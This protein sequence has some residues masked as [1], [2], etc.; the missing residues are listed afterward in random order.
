MAPQQFDPELAR[1][2]HLL[3]LAGDVPA[4]ELEVLAASRFTAAGWE[5]PTE[6]GGRRARTK[7]GPVGVLRL[8]RHSAL[9]GP[10]PLDRTGAGALGLPGAAGQVWVVHAP[11]E[12][13]EAPWPGAADRDGLGRGFP[14]G[15]P[16]REE[17][18]V[19]SWLVA[20]ARRLGGA[21]RV[22]GP[23]GSP[24]PV[25]VPDPAAAVDLTVW[26]DIWLGPDAALSVVRQ[27]VPRARLDGGVPWQGPPPGTGVRPARGAEDLDAQVRAALHQ[28]AERRDMEA[29]AHPEPRTSYGVLADLD[30]DGG[31]AVEIGGETELPQ[32]LAGVPWARAGAVAY[33]VT[34]APD[35]LSDL[36]MERPPIEH[37]IAR[38]RA[39]PLVNAVARS[40]HAAVA[41]EITD[42]MGFIV[43][44]ADL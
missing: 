4:E 41:G 11:V 24:A 27:A 16:I 23:V 6:G 42:M 12:R 19:V 9:H 15:L 37:R 30:L 44:P 34:W 14:A 39:V 18:R 31:L 17:E 7:G 20:A 22:S 1:D 26:S 21:L 25:L 36:G 5:D 40:L 2:H 3:A 10:Y 28:L 13:G 38:S 43:D 29:L 35:D 8:S 32:A 33:R